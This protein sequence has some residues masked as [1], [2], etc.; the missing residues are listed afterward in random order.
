MENCNFDHLIHL[1]MKLSFVAHEVNLYNKVV[2]L[3]GEQR[4]VS[5]IRFQSLV[6][7]EP[8]S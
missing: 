1:N 2:F 4:G 3:A 7:I 6:G 8:A 5:R